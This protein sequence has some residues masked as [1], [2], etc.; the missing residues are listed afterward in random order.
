MFALIIIG[1]NTTRPAPRRSVRVRAIGRLW[2]LLIE[3]STSQVVILQKF[4]A[5]L[6]A[7]A[8][9]KDDTVGELQDHIRVYSKAVA[10]TIWELQQMRAPDM[11]K[12]DGLAAQLTALADRLDGPGG[13]IDS[14]PDFPRDAKCVYNGAR[15]HFVHHF[16]LDIAKTI[17]KFGAVGAFCSSAQCGEAAAGGLKK[18]AR[19]SRATADRSVEEDRWAHNSGAA[20]DELRL[21]MCYR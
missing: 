7:M 20:A 10:D 6:V 4:V 13:L 9:P 5:S 12:V 18:G 17:T 16:Q 2:I 3:L 21:T 15:C 11:G 8:R 14:L 1:S 19:P